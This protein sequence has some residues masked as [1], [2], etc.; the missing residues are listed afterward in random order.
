M[1]P[2]SPIMISMPSRDGVDS[3]PCGKLA[4]A[5]TFLFAMASSLIVRHAL[6]AGL[7]P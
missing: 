5:L 3:I 6:A 4:L 2:G 1:R 7:T